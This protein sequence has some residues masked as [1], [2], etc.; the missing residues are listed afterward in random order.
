[1]GFISVW[2][3]KKQIKDGKVNR[4]FWCLLFSLPFLGIFDPVLQLLYCHLRMKDIITEFINILH[5][6]VVP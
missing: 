2:G 5:F 1:M 4:I 6:T 3:E